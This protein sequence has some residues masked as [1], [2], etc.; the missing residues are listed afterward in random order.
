MVTKFHEQTKR[1]ITEIPSQPEELTTALVSHHPEGLEFTSSRLLP[2]DERPS[3][4]TSFQDKATERLG[5]IQKGFSV[6]Q[7]QKWGSVLSQEGHAESEDSYASD[8][9][10]DLRWPAKYHHRP[11]QGHGRITSTGA[12]LNHVVMMGW[13]PNTVGFQNMQVLAVLSGS[14]V[15]TVY[16]ASPHRKRRCIATETKHDFSRW[17]ILWGVGGRLLIPGGYGPG[18]SQNPERYGGEYVTSF[19]WS[20]RVDRG[21]CLLAYMNDEDEA[22]LVQVQCVSFKNVDGKGMIIDRAHWIIEEA[23]RF[24]AS[25]PHQMLSVSFFFWNLQETSRPESNEGKGA[26]P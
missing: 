23:D 17:E 2:E 18:N 21:K 26:R 7:S 24:D 16:G 10:D 12:S 6:S 1:P 14:G 3:S 15:I 13:S 4:R 5:K 19:A 8:S 9:S 11:K 25:G 22:V 20:Q